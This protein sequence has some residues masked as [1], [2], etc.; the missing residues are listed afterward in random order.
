MA[1]PA[2]RIIQA[3]RE[4]CAG[5]PY[6]AVCPVAPLFI[7]T[8]A[9]P[10][11]RKLHP[12]APVL[13]RF[14][15][16]LRRAAAE[17]EAE[18]LSA[19]GGPDEGAALVAGCLLSQ[20]Y[21]DDPEPMR[22]LLEGINARGPRARPL[23]TLEEQIHRSAALLQDPAVPPLLRGRFRLRRPEREVTA[24]EAVRLVTRLLGGEAP[25][26]WWTD[27]VAP[28]DR[29][30]FEASFQLREKA[31]SDESTSGS[32]ALDLFFTA[33]AGTR[34][35]VF[36]YRRDG[37]GRQAVVPI[38][39]VRPDSLLKRLFK[40]FDTDAKKTHRIFAK[41]A[42]YLNNGYKGLD[43]R[44]LWEGLRSLDREQLIVLALYAPRLAKYIEKRAQFPGLYRLTKFLHQNVA[45]DTDTGAP[46]KDASGVHAPGA[47]PA[48]GAA[49]APGRR[50]ADEKVFERREL[51]GTIIET[52]GKETFKEFCRYVF[53]VAEAYRPG[54]AYSDLI[55]RIGEV[56]YFLTAVEGFNP[57]GLELSIGGKNPLAYIAYGLQPPAK[58]PRRRLKRLLDARAQFASEGTRNGAAAEIL[59]AIDRGLE[60]MARIHGYRSAAEM[61]RAVAAAA[62]GA[63]AGAGA[64]GGGAGASRPDQRPSQTK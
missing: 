62:A 23:S 37:H 49:A 53:R 46:E 39:S 54:P 25:A 29:G 48:A 60:Y 55:Y 47:G 5:C 64:S 61:E 19:M 11:G 22:A 17:P 33:R 38:E 9:P 20:L 57:K 26:V 44:M 6:F 12:H 34:S 59:A 41:I 3:A 21:W 51:V 58:E 42:R 16:E 35:S 1:S 24:Y 7:Q 27:A 50:S 32:G 63:S 13:A 8:E 43:K 30:A 4:A 18:L 2:L 28:E 52:Y 56:A 15:G 36:Y 10:G 40:T 31:L 45:D 14:L